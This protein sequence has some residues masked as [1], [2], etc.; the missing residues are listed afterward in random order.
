MLQ[1]WYSFILLIQLVRGRN[2]FTDPHP[3]FVV[4]KACVDNMRVFH[5]ENFGT[6]F[7]DVLKQK[8]YVGGK[9][10]FYVFDLNYALD[11]ASNVQN[12]TWSATR[13]A[14]DN[15]LIKG[16]A[17]W[18]CENY[19]LVFL[20]LNKNGTLL[21]CGTNSQAPRC[22]SF[23]DGGLKKYVEGNGIGKCPFRP[24]QK[25]TTLMVDGKIFS[26]SV[27]EYTGRDSQFTIFDGD[28]NL[29]ASKRLDSKWLKIPEFIASFEVAEWIVFFFREIAVDQISDDEAIYSRVAK[30]CKIDRGGD[31][32]LV[33]KWTTFQKAR[34]NCSFPGNFPFY[35]NYLQDVYM[36]KNGTVN[37]TTTFFGVFTTG[38]HEIPGSAVCAFDLDTIKYTFDQEPFKDNVLGPW[39]A[40]P[41][42]DV[43]IPRPGTCVEDS[44]SQHDDVLNFIK[45]H[46]LMHSSI[47]NN[48]D[49]NPLFYLTRADFRL[50]QIA[51]HRVE[52][53]RGEICTV[54]FL[55]SN[56]GRILKVI[57]FTDNFGKLR[58]NFLEEIPIR[59]QQHPESILN[60]EI[61]VNDANETVLLVNTNSTI[62]EVPL[63][64]CKDLSDNICQQDPYCRWTYGKCSRRNDPFDVENVRPYPEEHSSSVQTITVTSNPV[65]FSHAPFVVQNVSSMFPNSTTCKPYRFKNL[66]PLLYILLVF[67]W[68]AWLITTCVII[69]IQR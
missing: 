21:V 41:S 3:K 37:T 4:S 36:I 49:V 22:R 63:E 60:I 23:E 58:S 47:G 18:E 55:G 32:I 16:H 20:R 52:G 11:N 51:V 43:P 7:V 24:S 29:I 44:K 65:N 33:D 5:G 56:D 8:F 39:Y 6:M 69:F 26:G 48:Y 9:N 66:F 46:P 35:F 15:C 67:G 12:F 45:K 10:I 34:L 64:R 53:A 57:L 31:W 14:Q 42:D 28:R 30:V 61:V 54:L 25:Y 40:I 59:T 68:L 38:E 1:P 50:V 2:T 19:I 62:V 13:A 27:V 17:H